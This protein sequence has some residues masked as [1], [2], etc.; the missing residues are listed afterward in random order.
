MTQNVAA[1]LDVKRKRNELPPHLFSQLRTCQTAANEFLRQFWS[2]IFPPPT[3]GQILGG[4]STPAQRATRAAKMVGYLAKTH[5]KVRALVEAA[6]N[7]GVDATKV[8]IVSAISLAL[9]SALAEFLRMLGDETSTRCRG[10]S[11]LLS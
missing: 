3:E 6:Q 10:S 7:E 1:R 5:E 9:G 2:A 4:T 11:T 8:Q